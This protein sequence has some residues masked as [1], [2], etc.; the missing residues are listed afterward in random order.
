MFKRIGFLV[1]SVTALSIA[2]GG[3]A[4]AAIIANLATGLDASNNLITVGGTPDA[5]WTVA[6]PGGPSAQVVANGNPDW[7]GGWIPNGPNSAWIAVN[8]FSPYVNTQPYFR[9]F[10]LT[11]FDLSTV[12]ISGKWSIDD[13]GVV[14]LNGH[15]VSTLNSGFWGSLNPF[16]VP[17]SYLLPGQNVLSIEFSYSDFYL[18]GVRLE[19][20]VTGDPIVPEPSTVIIWSLLGVLG[21]TVGWWRRC[22]AA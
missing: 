3:F 8:A 19:G 1:L 2:S 22:K 13:A 12:S 4:N 15:L 17:T 21:I 6:L 14:L 7:Y 18:E 10:D 16:S 9:T 20:L 5:H 11:G